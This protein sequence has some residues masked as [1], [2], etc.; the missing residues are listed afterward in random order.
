MIHVCYSIYDND[1]RYSKFAGVSVLSIFE[2]TRERVT[3]HIM[4]NENFSAQNR[5]RFLALAEKFGQNIKFYN[6]EKITGDEIAYLEKLYPNQITA[7]VKGSM[8]RI[9]MEKVISAD[10]K[11]IIYLDTDTIV[12]LDIAELWQ[13][14]LGDNVLAAVSE[15][16]NGTDVKKLFNICAD[17][18]VKYE[19]YFNSGVLL[20]NLKKF[21]D[22]KNI[23]FDGLNFV[24]QHPNYRFLDQ[25]TLNY[26]FT[27]QRLKLP[28]RYNTFVKFARNSGDDMTQGKIYHFAGENVSFY[29]GGAFTNL[30]L[31]YFMKSDWFDRETFYRIHDTAN[32]IYAEQKEFA[33]KTSLICSGKNRAF[34]LDVNLLQRLKNTFMVQD[35]EEIIVADSRDAIRNLLDSM[36]ISRGKKVFFITVPYYREI[37]KILHKAGFVEGRD[38]INGFDF[39]NIAN[40]MSNALIK[41]L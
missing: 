17:G 21:R 30:W 18:F 10:V 14:D 13:V 39:L 34:F 15:I 11:K 1:G 7:K 9:W 32:K 16:E 19:N 38:F 24:S 29:E 22:A 20:I 23:M 33:V 8:Y 40:Q 37:V 3:V 25:D 2:N 31:D 4:H 35:N 6:M 5:E 28:V 26:C 36:T 12:N 27:H 41:N